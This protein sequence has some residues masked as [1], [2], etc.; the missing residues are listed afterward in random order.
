MYIAVGAEA[1]CAFGPPEACA[2]RLQGFIDAGV[3]TLILG[4]PWPDVEQV[5]RIAH[6][7]LPRLR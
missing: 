1:H 6:E 4:P 7:V 2:A 3:K 5:T